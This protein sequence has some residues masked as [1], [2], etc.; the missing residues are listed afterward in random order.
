[1]TVPKLP[2]GFTIDDQDAP[3]LPEGFSI[4]Q[5]KGMSKPPQPPEISGDSLDR[6]KKLLVKRAHGEEGLDEEIKGLFNELNEQRKQLPPRETPKPTQAQLDES[7][8]SVLEGIGE[9][10]TGA[11][12]MTPEMES[13]PN[14][15][16]APE[17]NEISSESLKSNL[18]TFTTGDEAEIQ[19]I[20]K[21]QFGDKVSFRK[22]EKNNVIVVFPSGSYP[23][24][25]P[26][27]SPQDVPNFMAE[28]LA[29]NP[30]ARAPSLI[31][32]AAKSAGG[33]AVLEGVDKLLGGDFSLKDVGISTAFG[34]GG[35]VLEDALSSAYRAIKGTGQADDLLMAADEAGIPILTTDALPPKNIVGK[36]GQQT[37]EKIPFAG[38]GGMRETQQGAREVAVSEVVEKYGTFSYKSIVE[39]LKNSKNKVK[40]AAGSVLNSTGETLDSFGEIPISNTKQAIAEAQEEMSK[41]GVIRSEGAIADLDTLI[42]AIDEAPQTFTSLKE[43][44]TAFREIVKGADKAERSQL[45]SRAKGILTKV[46]K[47][48]TDDMKSFAKSNLS[49]QK[50]KQWLKANSV[51]ANEAEK[52]TKTKIKNIL[53]TGDVQPEAVEKMLFSKKPSELKLLHSSLGADGRKNARAAIIS[54]ITNTLSK[55]VG[56]ISPNSFSTELKKHKDQIDVFF[57]GEERKQ[58]RGL[59]KALEAT[60]RAQDAAV[61]TPTGQQAIGGATVAAVASDPLTA[62]L[63]GGTIG[64]IAKI[65]ES[66]PVRNALLKIASVP[67]GSTAY[68]RAVEQLSFEVRFATQ[69]LKDEESN[70][71]KR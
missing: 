3:E 37:A 66:K 39:S 45:T 28:L 26:G 47:S 14:L 24:N 58:L 51:Y 42:K 32:A 2:E 22:D 10:I 44:R 61:T 31:G 27:L 16:S 53:D 48:M 9:M 71:T 54:K 18:A 34:A 59:E 55:R 7:G 60:R 36:M 64:S 67:K 69:A 62:I 49:E 12:R 5:P 68:L 1:M 57:K 41:A 63:T 70:Q 23:L 8:G 6:Y 56:G 19:K 15:G 33:E 52:M 65:Y 35:K 21:K 30:A 11:D 17:L 4:D 50:Y 20:F 25:K 13:L 38:T 40:Q 43:N 46:E 29:F